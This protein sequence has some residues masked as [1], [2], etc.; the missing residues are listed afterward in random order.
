MNQLNCRFLCRLCVAV[1]VLLTLSWNV[2]AKVKTDDSGKNLSFV[3]RVE[4]LKPGSSKENV[5]KVLGEPYKVAFVQQKKENKFYE[6]LSYF[7]RVSAIQ[8]ITYNFI[9]EDGELVGVF[10][11]ELVTSGFRKSKEEH[12]SVDMLLH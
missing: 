4:S 12:L 7:V 8:C 11:N 6:Q 3:A 1:L 9:F 5:K 10:E 2:S